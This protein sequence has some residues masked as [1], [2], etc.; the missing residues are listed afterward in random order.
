MTGGVQAPGGRLGGGLFHGE[1][2]VVLVFA[3][4]PH[5]PP[6]PK[7][8]QSFDY[9]LI[10]TDDFVNSLLEEVWTNAWTC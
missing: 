9:C 8:V 5:V 10:L 1:Y 7:G 2:V 3:V 6:R 4:L